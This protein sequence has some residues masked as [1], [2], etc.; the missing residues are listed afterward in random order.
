MLPEISWYFKNM[1][2]SELFKLVDDPKVR[3]D[4]RDWDPNIS[5]E[6]E[7]DDTRYRITSIRIVGRLQIGSRIL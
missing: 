2:K 1:K 7:L 3:R 6:R 5:W 4:W